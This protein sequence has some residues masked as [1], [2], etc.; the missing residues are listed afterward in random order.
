MC[1]GPQEDAPQEPPSTEGETRGDRALTY[2]LAPGREDPATGAGSPGHS[3]SAR[4]RQLDDSERSSRCPR[5]PSASPAMGREGTH[6]RA[7]ILTRHLLLLRRGYPGN[8]VSSREIARFPAQSR[9]WWVWP[10]G[11]MSAVTSKWKE[12]S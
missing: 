7:Q 10:A 12:R 3:V 5:Q 9:R 1:A 8:D 4:Q 2:T 11:K 6:P